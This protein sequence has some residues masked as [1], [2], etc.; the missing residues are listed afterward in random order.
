MY[1]IEA[2]PASTKRDPYESDIGAHDELQCPYPQL[3]SFTRRDKIFYYSTQLQ[4]NEVG[5]SL[6]I[7]HVQVS[8]RVRRIPSPVDYFIGTFL[9]AGTLGNVKLFYSIGS[10]G[11]CRYA[12]QGKF[13]KV[14]LLFG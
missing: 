5:F 7:C 6:L 11:A 8:L 4:L 9:F 3:I 13:G 1:S 14:T 10:T 2:P 12:Q